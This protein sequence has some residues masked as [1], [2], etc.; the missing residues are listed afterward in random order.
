LDHFKNKLD[1]SF[2]PLFFAEC[3]CRTQINH[4]N[5]GWV[6]C[7]L[8]HPF[9][10]ISRFEFFGTSILE[11]REYVFPIILLPKS[12]SWTF[13]LFWNTIGFEVFS[14]FIHTISLF[15]CFVNLLFQGYH[16]CRFYKSFNLDARSSATK[17]TSTPSA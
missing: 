17:S 9:Q 10:I 5:L 2:E 1:I 15:M 12:S 7:A 4:N 16:R 3:A 8:L 11:Q 14:H 13:L 6:R